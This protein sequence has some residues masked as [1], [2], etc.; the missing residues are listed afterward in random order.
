MPSSKLTPRPS[1]I[2]RTRRR[3]KAARARPGRSRVATALTMAFEWSAPVYLVAYLR[4]WTKIRWIWIALFFSFEIGI[5]VGL[6]I[7]AF[8]YTMLAL[9]PVLLTPEEIQRCFQRLKT[10]APANRASSPS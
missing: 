5:A 9:F 7:G 10:R 2:Q 8:A 3:L 1:Q 4:G 6:R